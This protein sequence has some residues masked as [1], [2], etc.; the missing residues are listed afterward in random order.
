MI[1]YCVNIDIDKILPKRLR[2]DI[3]HWARF[4][5]APNSEKVIMALSLEL[6]GI[7]WW[8]FAYTLILTKCTP[9]DYQMRFEIGWI[10]A[11]LKFWKKCDYC[12]MTFIVGRGF[13][14]RQILRKWI[15]LYLLN[16]VEYFDRLLR[17][18]WYYQDLAKEIVKCQFSSVEVLSVPNSEKKCKW[19]YFLNWVEY[20][21]EMLHTHWHIDKM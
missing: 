8:N 6:S 13:A 1:N 11:R 20:C 9:W 12:K 16:W 3:F 14:E 19:P 10:F 18:H 2:N 17:K 21:D 15:W 7:L 4:W 5:R